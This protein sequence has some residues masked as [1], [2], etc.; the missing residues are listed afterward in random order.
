[1][2]DPDGALLVRLELVRGRPGAAL[3]LAETALAATRGDSHA[4]T[5]RRGELAVLA[6]RALGWLSRGDEARALLGGRVDPARVLEAEELPALWAHAGERERA[7]AASDGPLGHL[8]ES[9]LAGAHPARGR[10]SDLEA[11][12]PYRAARLV[13]DFERVTPGLVP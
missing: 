5:T 3:A 6:A 10:W 2:T 1:K 8:W 4:E 12:E 11:L 7:V 9:V 13:F